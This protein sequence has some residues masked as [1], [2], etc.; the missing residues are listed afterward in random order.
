MSKWTA[1]QVITSIE[2][3]LHPKDSQGHPLPPDYC[4]VAHIVETA[5][6]NPASGEE[7]KVRRAIM[8]NLNRYELQERFAFVQDGDELYCLHVT[9]LA[10]EAQ[11]HLEFERKRRYDKKTLR[12]TRR[13]VALDKLKDKK[14]NTRTA[15]YQP[16]REHVGRLHGGR[17]GAAFTDER[18]LT[19]AEGT[20]VR[21]ACVRKDGTTRQVGKGFVALQIAEAQAAWADVD[22]EEA[23]KARKLAYAHRNG[24]K[25]AIIK[26]HKS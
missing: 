13:T 12:D 4:A 20:Y 9:G 15:S 25:A 8:R 6:A 19:G 10:Q 16:A 11:K 24:D 21:G 3:A 22:L 18:M 23:K 1:K 7:R 2:G 5:W 17:T 14:G 26:L